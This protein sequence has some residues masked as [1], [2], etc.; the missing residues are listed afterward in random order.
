[1]DNEFGQFQTV[2]ELTLEPFKKEEKRRIRRRNRKRRYLTRVYCR[3]MREE[4]WM[5][6][7]RRLI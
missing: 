2:P 4:P 7:P 1:M 3:R 5:H 6:S